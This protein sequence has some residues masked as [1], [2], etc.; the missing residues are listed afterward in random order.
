MQD[1]NDSIVMVG[2]MPH[3]PVLIPE[4]GGRRESQVEDSVRALRDLSRRLLRQDPARLVLISPHSP[5]RPRAFGVWMGR[6]LSGSFQPFGFPQVRCSVPNDLPFIERLQ[7]AAADLDL[8]LWDI[9]N[10]SLDHGALVPLYFLAEAGWTG[11]TTILSLNYPGEGGLDKLGESLARAAADSPGPTIVV[12]SGDMSHRL[13]EGAPAGFHPR[14]R[15]FDRIF[16]EHIRRG[17]YDGLKTIDPGLQELAAED[18]VDST[19]V[20]AGSVRYRRQG[21]E[22]LNYEGPFGV[23]YGVAILFQHDQPGATVA[24]GPAPEEITAEDLESMGAELLAAA[25]QSV[26][27]HFNGVMSDHGF[28]TDERL[29]QRRGVFVTLRTRDGRLRGCRGTIQPQHGNLLEEVRA[30]AVSSA[31]KDT[32]FDPVR[33]E[34]LP[35]LLFE[36]SVLSPPEDVSTTLELNPFVYGVIVRTEDGRRGVMLPNVEG[37]DT[38]EKQLDATRRKAFIQPGEAVML[39]RFRVDKFQE[40]Q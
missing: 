27:D 20:A 34:E 39:Q 8:A 11:P 10:T 21:H 15:D 9:T 25:R 26:E 36:V 6:R 17:D 12:A 24:A 29:R 31:F 2:L 16:V 38:V 7:T 23:G 33:A 30:V 13:R 37:L 18:A 4:I 40:T 28:T 32:R 35:D 3:A 5:R 1:P 14:A 19:L 22:V